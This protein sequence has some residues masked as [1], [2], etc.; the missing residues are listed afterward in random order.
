[1][2]ERCLLRG[3]TDPPSQGG[4]HGVRHGG[5]LFC[6]AGAACVECNTPT[7]CPGQDTECQMRA[8]NLGACGVAYAPPGTPAGSSTSGDCKKNQ[9][10]G[11]GVI[12]SV[13]DD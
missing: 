6:S 5:S 12:E 8:C 4:R 7:Q 2:H 10:N 9:C 13:N 11:A 1:M 3:D